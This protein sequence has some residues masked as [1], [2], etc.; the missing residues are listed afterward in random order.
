MAYPKPAPPLQ[1]S[2]PSALGRCGT[3]VP[4]HHSVETLTSPWLGAGRVQPVGEGAG[5]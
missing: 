4:A 5:E 3:H 1:S 2:N